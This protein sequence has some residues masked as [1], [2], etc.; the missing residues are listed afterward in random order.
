MASWCSMQ[1][2][3]NPC[4]TVAST[5]W[6]RCWLLD[7]AI[8]VTTRCTSASPARSSWAAS[9]AV[10]ASARS[11]NRISRRWLSVEVVAHYGRPSAVRLSVANAVQERYGRKSWTEIYKT[12]PEGRVSGA[13]LSRGQSKVERRL[14]IGRGFGS[15]AV[16]AWFVL[17]SS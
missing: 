13:A 1:T 10:T 16:A 6:M 11:G 8:W 3:R 12:A 5:V 4:V 17:E 9:A 14:P 7:S 2:P 15:C